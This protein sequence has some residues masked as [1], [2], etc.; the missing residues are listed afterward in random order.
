MVLPK[1]LCVFLLRIVAIIDDSGCTPLPVLLHE[2]GFLSLATLGHNTLQYLMAKILEPLIHV[3]LLHI[4]QR[5]KV[6]AMYGSLVSAFFF[7]SSFISSL[8]KER[9]CMSNI[10][11]A[12]F[13]SYLHFITKIRQFG[14]IPHLLAVRLSKTMIA[15]TFVLVIQSLQNKNILLFAYSF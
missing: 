9:G 1:R 10:F 14:P 2:G 3:R 11:C 8:C 12:Y 6:E 4:S 13:T 7:I 15:C 5:A